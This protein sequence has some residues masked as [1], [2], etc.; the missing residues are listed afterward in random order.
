MEQ[1]ELKPYFITRELLPEN[2][3]TPIHFMDLKEFPEYLFYRRNHFSYPLLIEDLFHFHILG[4]VVNSRTFHLESIRSMPSRSVTAILECAGNKRSFFE[5]KTYGEQ[6]ERGAIGQGTWRGVPLSYLL[7]LAG[8]KES[9][10]EVVVEGWDVGRRVDLPGIHPFARSLSMEKAMHPDTIIAYEFNGYPLTFRH[11]FPFRLVVPQWYAMASVKWVKRILVIDHAFQGPY[12]TIDY[13]YYPNPQDDQ[14]KV[15]V[16][17]LNVNSS[18]QRPLDHSLLPKGRHYIQGI[19][20][21]GM[22]EINRV[23]ISLDGGGDWVE[24]RLYRYPNQSRAWAHWFYEWEIQQA[25]EYLIMSRSEDTYG[26]IQ[27]LSPK[28]NRKGYGY[29]AADRA[30]VRVM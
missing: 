10:L 27:P 25:G 24:A 6:W 18:I 11:G 7:Q 13:Q 28:W 14:Q 23:Q 29:N 17:I 19:A 1:G 2:Q 15:P 3:E 4:E 20:W 22:G 21:T 9:S 8:L 16:T 12:Q 5:P 26:R 30:R